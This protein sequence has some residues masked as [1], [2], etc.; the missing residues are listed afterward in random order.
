MKT[1][2]PVIISHIWE[3]TNQFSVYVYMQMYIN[4]KSNYKRVFLALNDMFSL[5]KFCLFLGKV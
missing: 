2:S 4:L 1:I 5:R 3:H